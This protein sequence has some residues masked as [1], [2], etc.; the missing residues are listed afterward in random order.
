MVVPCLT[1]NKYYYRLSYEKQHKS[2]QVTEQNGSIPITQKTVCNEFGNIK[3]EMIRQGVF[4]RL[5]GLL[6]AK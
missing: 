5:Y 4:E 3:G 6:Y 2:K 1:S